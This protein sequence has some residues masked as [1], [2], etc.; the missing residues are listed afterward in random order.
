MCGA[1]ARRD[2]ARAVGLRGRPERRRRHL[3]LVRRPPRR[4]RV[5][6]GGRAPRHLAARPP[7]R[8]GGRAGGRRAR[9]RRARLGERQPLGAGRP[10]PQRRDRRAHARHAR[11]PTSTARCVEATAF[12]ARKIVETFEDAGVPVDDFVVA[13][14]LLKNQFVMQ[15]Y[16]DVLRRP[17]HLIGSDQGPALGSAIHAAVAAGAHPDVR[18]AAAAMGKLERDAYAPGRRRGRR[19]RRAV[20][21]LHARCTTTS[22]ATTTTSCTGCGGRSESSS[23]ER[24]RPPA[25]RRR[26][27]R[28]R[29]ARAR[30]GRRRE[31]RPRRG[32]RAVRLR[33]A[34]V[35]RGRDR[36]RAGWPARSCSATSSRAWSRAGRSTGAAS[37]STR[38]CRA[39]AA[40]AAGRATRTCARTSSSPATA[41]ATAACAS[42]WPGRPRRCTRCR[43]SMDGVDRR[44]ARAAGRRASTRFD[45]G[46]VH[47]R[48]RRGGRRLRADRAAADPGRAGRGRAR[49][50]RRRSARPPAR[51][52]RAGAGAELVAAPEDV[53]AGADVDVAF[54]VAG[55]DEAVDLAHAG[56]PAGRARRARRHPGRRPHLVPRLARPP[57]GPDDRDGRGG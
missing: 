7:L 25:R 30:A 15:I 49:D 1:V 40:S 54:E 14:G 46:H 16:A 27:P 28:R 41:T 9:A 31:P 48:R 5:P 34:L 12:G 44:D 52:G 47:A 24:G 11:R 37:R 42:T 21:A 36:R 19:L 22:A 50:A 18:A 53:P 38:R 6:R 8:A 33:P 39:G 26:H 45:L 13:G 55:T 2:H 32:G 3:R 20:H 43:T 57:Q 23:I 10:R 17:L 56:R 35:R 29:R 4:P 51:G